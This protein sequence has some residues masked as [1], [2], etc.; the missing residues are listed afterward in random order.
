MIEI[1]VPIDSEKAEEAAEILTAIDLYNVCYNAPIEITTDSNG[2]GYFE[3]D[4][5]KTSLSVFVE[6]NKEEVK[7]YIDTI[8]DALGIRKGIEYREVEEQNW[9]QPFEPVDLNNGWVISNPADIWRFED[10]KTISFESQGAFGTGLHETTQDCL[11][12]ILDMDYSGRSVLDL[13][14]GSGILSFAAGLK[15]AKKIVAVDIKDVKDEIL[16]NAS[17]NNLDNIEVM[18]GDVMADGMDTGKYFD[19]IFINIGGEETLAAMKFI[20]S[21]LQPG[22]LLL[23]SGLVE[24]S[25]EEISTSIKMKGYETIKKTQTN[26]WVTTLFKKI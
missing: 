7:S 2:Y 22:G 23:V 18:I 11:R 14:A 16:Y 5:V 26:E 9:Q 15:N 25:Y 24:W 17:L 10:K 3:K 1:I 8:S 20:N 4:H 19:D 13:G 6:C 12:M 21:A